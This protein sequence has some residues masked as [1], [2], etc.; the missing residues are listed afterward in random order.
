MAGVSGGANKTGII[1]NGVESERRFRRQ[2][3]PRQR[4]RVSAQRMAT[5]IFAGGCAIGRAAIAP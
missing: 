3:T 2:L 5:T 4:A 1:G